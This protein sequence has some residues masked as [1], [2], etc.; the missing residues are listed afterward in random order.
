MNESAPAPRRRWQPSGPLVGLLA[1]LG[2]FVLLLALKGE[3]RTFLSLANLQVL[4]HKSAIPSV[5]A[6]GMLL[7]IVSGGIDLSV[8]SVCALVTVVT[9]QCY[10]LVYNGPEYVLPSLLPENWMDWL[11]EGNR[12]PAG[13]ESVLWASLTA[14]PFGVLVGG[15]CG[16]VNGLVITRLRLT[17]FV[18]TLGMLS[19]A[20]GLAVYLAG[21]TRVSFRGPRPAWVDALASTGSERLIFDPGVWS[22]GLL[23][24][25][26][27]ILMRF[28]VLGRHTYAIGSNEATARLCGVAVDRNK[29][30]LYGL[31]GLLAGWAGVLLF[32]HGNGGDPNAGAGLELDVIAAVVIGGASLSGGQGTVMGA[33]LG[34]LILGVLENGVSFFG[35]PVEVKFIL[36]GAI[37]IVNTALSVWQRQRM[38]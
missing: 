4:L 22:V 18:A 35:V 24:V 21:R 26:T 2:L 8:G 11:R 38:A 29:V 12:L 14:I 27:F 10:R 19:V 13:T 36:I 30:I 33:L 9:M 23:A 5:C 31:A 6:L 3:L 15:L 25:L 20:R 7:I 16:L 32:A 1:L 37:V 17:P 28:T 34:V